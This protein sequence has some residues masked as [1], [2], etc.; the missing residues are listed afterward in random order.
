M[1]RQ[2]LFQAQTKSERKSSADFSDVRCEE[3]I[4][5]FVFGMLLNAKAMKCVQAVLTFDTALR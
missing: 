5:L 1:L 2:V 4:Q 3:V